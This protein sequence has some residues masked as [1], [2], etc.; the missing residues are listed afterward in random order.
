MQNYNGG[1][2]GETYGMYVRKEKCIQGFEG[3]EHFKPRRRCTDDI[4]IN[5]KEE[6]WGRKG[7][8]WKKL[9]WYTSKF[10]AVGKK[11]LTLQAAQNDREF[12]DWQQKY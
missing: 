5:C 8:K 2:L 4:N 7:M 10:Q 6:K 11:V 9:T 3:E 12:F 1:E